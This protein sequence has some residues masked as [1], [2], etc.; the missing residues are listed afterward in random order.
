[1]KKY[2]YSFIALFAAFTMAAQGT[3][4]R[5]TAP[6]PGPA[7]TPEIASYESFEL[8]NG[9]KVFVVEDHKLP[10]VS[11]SLIIDRDPI[12]EGAKAGYVSIAGDLIGAGT[13]TKTKA[14]LD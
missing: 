10:R 12:V 4:D 6:T 3:I 5:S 13:S 7:R 14:Q 8:K 2:I 1:M 9:L 11:M